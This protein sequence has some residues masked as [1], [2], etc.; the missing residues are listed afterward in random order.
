MVITAEPGLQFSPG[1]VYFPCGRLGYLHILHA[2]A[3][4]FILQFRSE[5]GTHQRFLPEHLTRFRIFQV[6]FQFDKALVPVSQ[7]LNQ[8]AQ[9]FFC[10]LQ[11]F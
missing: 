9:V 1:A 7:G 6:L 5:T 4:K 3:V 8:V 2:K 11:I 10:L